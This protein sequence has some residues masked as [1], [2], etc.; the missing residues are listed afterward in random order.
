MCLSNVAWNCSIIVE[1]DV[2]TAISA[3]YCFEGLGREMAMLVHSVHGLFCLFE[4]SVRIKILIIIINNLNF[5]FTFFYQICNG[6]YGSGIFSCYLL[7]YFPALQRDD[8]DWLASD[9]MPWQQA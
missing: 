6:D 5:T 3:T 4:L 2:C 7:I 8:A 9:V 1:N